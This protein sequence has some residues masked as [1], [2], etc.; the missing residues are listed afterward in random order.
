MKLVWCP[1]V[2]KASPI[3]LF[4]ELINVFPRQP[5]V[6]AFYLISGPRNSNGLHKE[7]TH[8]SG[9]G[10]PRCKALPS[11]ALEHTRTEAWTQMVHELSSCPLMKALGECTCLSLT[12]FQ[13]T[14]TDILF[15][16]LGCITRP[17]K[18][19]YCLLTSKLT[20]SVS[21]RVK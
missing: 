5:V 6:Y 4:Y 2:I 3:S 7:Q 10:C 21:L 9:P 11:V 19:D 18:K 8:D 14:W 16:S 1:C 12:L 20:A 17:N 13:P 15:R